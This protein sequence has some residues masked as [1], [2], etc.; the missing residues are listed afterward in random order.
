[1]AY[2]VRRLAVGDVERF[3]ALRLRGLLESP[4]AFGETAAHFGG[5]SIAELR[6]QFE[7]SAGRGGFRL[8]AFHPRG[9]LHGVVGLF[10]EEGEKSSHR[11]VVWGMYVAPEARG[12]GLGR[13]LMAQLIEE[14][15]S[16]PGLLQLHLAVVT[17]NEPAVKLYRS[18][19]FAPYGTD[20]GA[21]N[22]DGQLLDEYLL[23]YRLKS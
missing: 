12:Q 15:Q 2:Q 11:G 17:T 3:R 19:G 13:A 23:C 5:V 18:L 14:A 20:P 1:M 7:L 16:V 22:I 6:S 21:L 8:G 10:R 9:E 4:A